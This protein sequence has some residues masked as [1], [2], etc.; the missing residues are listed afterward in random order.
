MLDLYADWCISC[1]VMERN[2][3]PRPEVSD[4]LARFY[5]VRADVTENSEAH[6]AL[7]NEFGLF[8]PPSF[9]FFSEDGDQLADFTVQGEIDADGLTAHLD[10]VLTAN[11]SGAGEQYALN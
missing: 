8:G 9:V 7:L 11:G 4:R 5:L 2:V 6:K 1:K 3:F 10:R